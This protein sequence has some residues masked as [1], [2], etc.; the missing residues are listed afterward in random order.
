LRQYQVANVV[1]AGASKSAHITYAVVRPFNRW[2]FEMQ[3]DK[4]KKSIAR[5]KL[6]D[7]G[8]W[9]VEKGISKRGDL[10]IN[11][12]V[13][14]VEKITASTIAE[15]Y[16]QPAD[17]YADE[18]AHAD[19]RNVAAYIAKRSQMPNSEEYAGRIYGSFGSFKKPLA[20]LVEGKDTPPL[21]AAAALNQ[22]IKSAGFI[23]KQNVDGEAENRKRLRELYELEK[24]AAVADYVYIPGEGLMSRE[25]ARQAGHNFV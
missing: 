5:K 22:M 14:S 13:G 11:V 4:M 8:V 25:A 15:L 1:E 16:N 10:H 12:I 2:D 7:G 18:V 6:I 17:V 20:A 24:E 9:T 3:F 21:I 19:V 23:A